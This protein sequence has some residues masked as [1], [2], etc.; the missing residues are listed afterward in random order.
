MADGFVLV[1][2]WYEWIIGGLYSRR[3]CTL[4]PNKNMHFH[5]RHY[6]TH[7]NEDDGL[8]LTH[9]ETKARGDAD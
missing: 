3:M 5:N 1:V 7:L 6:N 8:L 4:H 2:Q 9:T